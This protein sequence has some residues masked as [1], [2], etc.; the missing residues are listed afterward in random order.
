MV[1]IDTKVV[2]TSKKWLTLVQLWITLVHKLL[3]LV[4]KWLTLV[5]K[6]FTL[7]QK[8]STLVQKWLILIKKWLTF[9]HTWLR[10]VQKWSTLVHNWSTLV[11]KWLTLIHKWLN[12]HFVPTPLAERAGVTWHRRQAESTSS[13]VASLSFPAVCF[14]SLLLVPYS[15]FRHAPHNG[16]LGFEADCKHR[17]PEAGGVCQ[18][19]EWCEIGTRTVVLGSDHFNWQSRW[20][21][22]QLYREFCLCYICE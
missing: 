18:C 17:P 14:P 12:V 6:W 1:S 2:N 8:W 5:Q 4:Q 11:H 7:V 22:R 16:C 15:Q 21:K 19:G 3:T 13:Y 20:V 9:V 10:L